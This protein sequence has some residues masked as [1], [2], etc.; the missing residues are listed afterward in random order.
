M[1][2]QAARSKAQVVCHCGASCRAALCCCVLCC[3]CRVALRVV[4]PPPPP[5]LFLVWCGPVPRW[6]GCAVARFAVCVALCFAGVCA[7]LFGA[8]LC[9]LRQLERPSPSPFSKCLAVNDPC[10]YHWPLAAYLHECG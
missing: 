10:S 4:V 8:V 9:R 3:L 1:V 6:L 7:V 5:L 2:P